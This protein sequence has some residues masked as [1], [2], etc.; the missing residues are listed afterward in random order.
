MGGEIELRKRYL[1][2]TDEKLVSL[3]QE[4]AAAYTEAAWPLLQEEM[5]RRGLRPPPTPR[6]AAESTQEPSVKHTHA[7]LPLGRWGEVLNVPE[8]VEDLSDQDLLGLGGQVMQVSKQDLEWAATQGL[9]SPTQADALWRALEYRAAGRSR[10]DLAHLA[11]Y[12]GALA[13]I[14][15]MSWFITDAWERFGGGGIFLIAVAYA[16][17]FTLAG[18]TLWFRQNLQV[19]GGLLFTI[20]VWM[21]PLAIYGLQ[22]RF[23]LWLQQDPGVY[24]G[25]YEWIKGGW[26]L[27]EVGTIGAGLVALRFVRFPFLTFPVA[28]ALWFMSMDVTPLLYG[29]TNITWDQRSWVSLWFGVGVLVMSYLVDRRMSEDYAFW[30][31]LFGLLAFWG[32]LSLTKSESEVTKA[33]YCLI[34]LGLMMLSVLLDRRVFMVFGALGIFYYLAHLAYQVFKDSLLFPFALSA[35]GVAIIVLGILYQKNRQRIEAVLLGGMPAAVRQH[36]PMERIRRG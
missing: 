36:L 19:P 23:G 24:R 17:C 8:R 32:G 9:L 16:A 10:F 30:G 21:T 27:M 33:L 13:V 6:P 22:R 3:F 29:Q 11:Y 15:A 4:G 14:S 7:V 1:A 20:A 5:T 25:Y 35:V 26:F 2:A 34:N 28:F 12:L 31:Y 18:Y